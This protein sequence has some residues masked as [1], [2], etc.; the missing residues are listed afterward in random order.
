[1]P[2]RARWPSSTR[3]AAEPN[4]APAPRWPSRCS[5]G[6]WSCGARADR[7]D[8]LDRAQTLR[9]RHA[10]RRKRQRPL[11]SLDLR[12]DVRAR[13]RNAG[14]I[15]GLSAGDAAGYRPGH[16]GARR[17]AARDVANATTRARLAELSVRSGELREERARLQEER[18]DASR[19]LERVRHERSDLDEE[20]RRFGA[21]A[22]ERARTGLR[23]FVRELQRRADEAA[24]DARQRRKVRVSHAQTARL[25]ETVEAIRRDLGIRPGER[26]PGAGEPNLRAGRS[27]ARPLVESECDGRRGLG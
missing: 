26:N 16:R 24:A 19:E 23:D 6:C 18:R 25:A 5:N 17:G 27:R 21:R 10:G 4:R 13:R 9:P 12:A 8:A 14:P 1:M 15:A 22:E 20:R 3:S 2:T 11:R 7:L